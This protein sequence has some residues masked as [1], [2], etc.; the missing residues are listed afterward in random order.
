MLVLLFIMSC[1]S[2]GMLIYE[3]EVE[4]IIEVESECEVLVE[5]TAFDFSDLWVDS[6][7]QVRALD[8]VDIFWVID[9]SGSMT[10]DQPA[11]L[12]GI[13]VMMNNLPPTGWRLM[14][15]PSD[16]RRVSDR[17][18]FPI[19]PGD[20]IAD[21]EAMYNDQVAGQYEA[22]FDAVIEY[23][24]YNAYARTWLRQDAAL[25]IVFVS[26]ENDQSQEHVISEYEFISWAQLQRS[27]VFV[28]SIVNVPNDQSVC[29]NN[30]SP[31]A[32]GE[33]YINATNYFGG[34]VVDICSQDW[35]AGVAQ[36]AEQITPIEWL[37]LTHTPLNPNWIYVYIDGVLNTDWVYNSSLNRVE[38]T[39]IPDGGA[40]VEVAYNY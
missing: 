21:I 10:D 22:G 23:I 11:I 27:N 34:N 14:I 12:A 37:E 3:K 17:N 19:V 28:A 39:T 4:T 20:T 26:D 7:T 32:V 9:P 1:M 13:Q 38:F 8:G 33:R 18:Y 35:S 6:F 29:T 40:L 30:V 36:A 2:D 25:L 15:I 24:D 31:V 16:F 5:D